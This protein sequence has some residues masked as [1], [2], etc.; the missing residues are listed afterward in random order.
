LFAAVFIFPG[1]TRGQG[2]ISDGIAIGHISGFRVSPNITDQN[3]FID[4][5]TRHNILQKM[6]INL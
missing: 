6:N 4:T 2:N 3:Y 5:S 1:F